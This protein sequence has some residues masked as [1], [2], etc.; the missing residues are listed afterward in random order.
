MERNTLRG[1]PTKNSKEAPLHSAP[2]RSGRCDPPA[3]APDPV[4]R[5]R[6]RRK[7]A[8][9]SGSFRFAGDRSDVWIEWAA[10]GSIRRRRTKTDQNGVDPTAE[11]Q[12]GPKRG[13]VSTA[14]FGARRCD[15][16]SARALR[17]VAA[18]KRASKRA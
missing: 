4:G 5:I 9:E 7:A 15:H 3:P 13:R 8:V 2:S 16:A 18:S 14:R 10:A 6:G 11:D 1:S 17:R 12:N